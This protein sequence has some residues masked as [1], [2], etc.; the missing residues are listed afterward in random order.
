MIFD[1]SVWSMILVGIKET[2]LMVAISSV[3]SYVLGIPLGI[4]LVV[5]DKNGIKPMPKV[6]S[7]I[8][9]IINILRSIPFMILLIMVLPVTRLIVG[10]TLGWKAVVPPLVFAAA[11]YIARMVESSLKETDAGIIEA[12]KSMGA[13]NMQIITKVY[14]PEAKPSLITGAAISITTI[15]GYSAMAGF[16]GGGGLGTIA[17]NYGYYRY[18]TDIMIVT[19]IIL[20]LIVQLIQEAGTRI[21]RN[22]DKR[23]R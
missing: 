15:L 18:Q 23:I 22:T 3:I 7:I 8:G 4:I 11:P 6:N 14:L 17:I 12:A 10:T 1:A 13:S 19:V 5:T 16:V 2:L 20:V 21:T 9:V